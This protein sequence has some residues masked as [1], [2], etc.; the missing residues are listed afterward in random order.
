MSPSSTSTTRTARG[1]RRASSATAR[2][3]DGRDRRADADLRATDIAQR[4]RRLDVHRRRPGRCAR[5]CPA[6]STSS[7]S[8]GAVAAARALGVDD[9]TIVAALPRRRPR[10]RTLRAGRRGPGLRAC[11]STTRTRPTRWRTCCAAA[12]PLTRGPLIC[13]FGCGGDRDRGKR[14]LMGEIAARL[15]TVTIV[16]SDN[17]RSED[18]AAIVDEIVAGIAA[19]APA[20]EAIV[21]RRAAIE[22]AV[23]AGRSPATSSS[24]PARATSRARSSRAGA[25]CRSTTSPSRARRCVRDWSPERVAAAARR[26]R[27]RRPARPSAAARPG[28]RA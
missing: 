7:T 4:L 9:A 20:V 1:W 18:P 27:S 3:R 22:R 25:S 8:L 10:A 26:A 13:V 14:P 15:P 21:D 12:R 5:R 28:R 19:A 2:A 24:S 16:T 11:S 23:G 17:P 6:A